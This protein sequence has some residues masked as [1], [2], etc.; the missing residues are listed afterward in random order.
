MIARTTSPPRRTMVRWCNMRGEGWASP[1]VHA[2]AGGRLPWEAVGYLGR[3]ESASSCY[4]CGRHA[5]LLRHGWCGMIRYQRPSYSARL[6]C[7]RSVPWSG[8]GSR[9]R[10]DKSSQVKAKQFTDLW[11]RAPYMWLEYAQTVQTARASPPPTVC[12][13]ESCQAARRASSKGLTAASQ[14]NWRAFPCF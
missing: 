7:A 6:R 1:S 13:L 5:W 2:A 12:P 11:R 14:S 10:S 3:G 9:A 4:I 8:G